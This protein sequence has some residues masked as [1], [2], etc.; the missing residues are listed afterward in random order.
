VTIITE[1]NIIENK[2]DFSLLSAQ[3]SEIEQMIGRVF[4][5]YPQNEHWELFIQKSR[6]AELGLPQNLWKAKSP[7]VIIKELQK[8]FSAN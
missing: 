1:T 5:L 3:R 2:I 7:E 4:R 8:H 6:A